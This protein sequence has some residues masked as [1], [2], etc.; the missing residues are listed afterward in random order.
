MHKYSFRFLI[1]SSGIIFNL[2]SNPAFAHLG[3]FGEFAGHSHI[4]GALLGGLAVGLAGILAT[5]SKR[6]KD[7]DAKTTDDALGDSS[8][9]GDENPDIAEGAEQNA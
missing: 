1:F 4:A 7:K 8:V 6:S 9:D 5:H 2:T 3:H